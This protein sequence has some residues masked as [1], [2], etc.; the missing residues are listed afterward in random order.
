MTLE[1]EDELAEYARVRSLIM[2]FIPSR[3]V[4][5]LARA[6]VFAILNERPLGT[7]QLAAELQLDRDAL[8]RMLDLAEQTELL[9]AVAERWELTDGGKLL[10][11]PLRALCDLMSAEAF[12]CWTGAEISL[13]TGENAFAARN[14]ADYFTW[15][16]ENP[17]EAEA[18]DAAQAALAVDRSRSLADVPWMSESLIV[19]VGGGTGTFAHTAVRLSGG[20]TPAIVFDLSPHPDRAEGD[21]IEFLQ[22]N[23]FDGVP[24]GG[25]TYILAQVLHDWSDHEAAVILGNC[26]SAMR[27]D[28]RILVVERVRDEPA[29]VLNLSLDLHMMVLLGGRERSLDEWTDLFSA[30]GLTIRRH[31]VGFSSH[32][33]ELGRA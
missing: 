30:A 27:P 3:T 33:F 19:D 9:T 31:G 14:G 29:D 24:Q 11:G 5:V 13:R 6:G 28:G 10:C 32:V 22:G 8:S 15:L 23:F 7:S 2:G 18:F 26:V 25:S 4:S 16:K 21:Q 20:R 1:S 12:E 17:L